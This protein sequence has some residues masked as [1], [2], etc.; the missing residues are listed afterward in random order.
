[1]APAADIGIRPT[2]RDELD[3]LVDIYLS[4]AR[5]HHSLDPDLYRVPEPDAVAERLA[6]RLDGRGRA[7]DAQGRRP[8]SSF[9][10]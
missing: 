3:A 4:G 9:A 6:R 10:R 7:M 5:H 8:V 2:N 1:M